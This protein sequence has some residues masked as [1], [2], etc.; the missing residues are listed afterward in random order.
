[1]LSIINKIKKDTNNQNNITYRKKKI[2]YKT[3]YI[4]FNE[5]ISSSETISNYIIRSLNKIYLPTYNNLINKISNFTYQAINTYQHLTYSI[6][7]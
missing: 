3:I 4:I 1:M 5:T 6:T 2:I 7:H